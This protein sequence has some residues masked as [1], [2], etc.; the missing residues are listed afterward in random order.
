M[1]HVHL[2]HSL[3]IKKFVF[4]IWPLQKGL[5]PLPGKLPKRSEKGF[6]GP[7]GPGVRSAS[8]KNEKAAQRVSFGAGHPADVHAD[9][10]ADARGQKLRSSPRNPGKINMSVRTSMTRRRGRP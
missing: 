8:V 3:E 6:P 5:F 2:L 4:N 7:L 1:V 10:P 9:I